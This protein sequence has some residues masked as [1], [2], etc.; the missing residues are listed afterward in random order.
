M[1]EQSDQQGMSTWK[2]LARIA[3]S[4]LF[5]GLFYSIWLSVFLLSSPDRALIETILWLAAPLATAIGFTLGI[6]IFDHFCRNARLPFIKL[7][8]WPLVGCII[9]ALV[10]Y[11]FGPM[12]IVFSMLAF[13][14]IS[15]AAR[16]VVSAR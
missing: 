5:G 15:V 7:I 13:G 9:G 14:T 10:V 11:W 2:R 6:M 4:T 3:T 8:S 1:I 12:L 16:E